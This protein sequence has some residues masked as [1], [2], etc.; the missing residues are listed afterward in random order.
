[1]LEALNALKAYQDVLIRIAELDR[2]LNMVPEEVSNL[3]TEWKAIQERLTD[4]QTR[5]A[6]LEEELKKRKVELQ[7]AGV[8]AEKYEKD[9]H[10]VTNN[11][12]YH[13]VLKEIDTAKRTIHN[14]EEDIEK[15][16]TEISELESGIEECVALEKESKAKYETAKEE[17]LNGQEEN[18]KEFEEKQALKAKYSA[19]VPKDLLRKFERISDRRNGVGLAMC[20]SSV[21]QACN[22]RVRQVVVDRLR[23]FEKVITCESCKRILY[24]ADSE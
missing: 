1:M 16:R 24:F 11:K 6:N 22:V 19:K 14:L 21:C 15:R 7:D 18:K 12:E 20:V 2:L 9:L 17:W 8:K 10:Q 5:K 13:A 4:L 23:R 3:E